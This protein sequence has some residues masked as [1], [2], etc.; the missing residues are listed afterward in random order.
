MYLQ[1]VL[2]RDIQCPENAS[3]GIPLYIESFDEAT[4]FAKQVR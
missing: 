1:I 3:D 4:E 2:G